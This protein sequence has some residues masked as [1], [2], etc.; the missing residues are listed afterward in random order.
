MTNPFKALSDK[1]FLRLYFP[2]TISLLGDTFTR[3]GIAIEAKYTI[4]IS[5][6]RVL[7][8]NFSK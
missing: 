2:Q 3:V 4:S 1:I 7:L 8:Y 5:Q 6:E